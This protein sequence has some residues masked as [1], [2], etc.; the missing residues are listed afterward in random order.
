MLRP[1]LS[2][3]LFG[4]A[5][6]LSW[7]TGDFSGGLATKRTS[8]NGVVVLSQ[9][10]SLLLLMLSAIL[11]PEETN[12]VQDMII[13]GIA[14]VCGVAG[15]IALYTGLARGPMGIVAPVSAVVAAL[16]PVLFSILSEGIPKLGVILGFGIALIAVWLISQG[17]QE[18]KLR[19]VDFRLPVYA[20]LGFG[21]F[22]IL[23]DQVSGNAILW[24]L[25]SA[26]IA[27]IVVVLVFGLLT[28]N[29]DLPSYNL[30]PIIALAGIF[31][32]GGNVFFAL[33]TRFGRLD[34]SAVL[35]SLYPAV[36]VLLAW[37][38]LKE[39]LTIWQWVGVLLAL[40]AVILIAF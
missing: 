22:F 27:S 19:L 29:I 18:K 8:V 20:G 10:V 39:R 23:I 26:R 2:I 5:S 21:I 14:G 32:T 1:G 24:P 35:A 3:I 38:I 4:L 15:L 25:V 16:V 11:I 17:D 13:G 36:T 31:D 40:I 6:A 12:T 28:S 30:L 34:I 9:F 7:G 37:L 33:A